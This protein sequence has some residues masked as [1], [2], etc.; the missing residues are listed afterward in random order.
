M[1]TFDLLSETF[2]ALFSNK[3][4]S[5]LTVL[6]IVIGIGSVITMVSIGQGAQ[7]SIEESINSMGSNLLSI[8]SGTQRGPGVSVSAGRG[9]AK[10]LKL[11]DAEAIKEQ[12]SQ[13]KAVASE[14]SSRYQVTAKGTNTNTTVTGTVPDYTI[15][16]NVEVDLGSFLAEQNIKSASKV[17]VLGPSAR[18]DLFGEDAD[19]VGKTVRIKN[20]DFKVIG[21]T[22]EK[23]GSGPNNQDDVIY[24]PITVAQRYFSGD[25]YV[26]TINVAAES[27]DAMTAVEEDI[28]NLLITRHKIKDPTVLDFSIM[29]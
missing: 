14:V 26:S 1:K 19:P 21:V 3:V 22:K 23:G 20:I 12:I 24:I 5:G 10:S 7:N 9:S 29:N 13:I 27:S 17:A 16:K 6:G 25:E 28:T 15:V 4:R 11:S 18:D 2:S 8:M